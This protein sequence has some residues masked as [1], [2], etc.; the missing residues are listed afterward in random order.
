MLLRRRFE[1]TTV[2]G[3]GELCP[4]LLPAASARPGQPEN[5]V[6]CPAEQYPLFSYGTARRPKMG[7]PPE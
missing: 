5:R 7:L 6:L 4:A 1:P 2:R 3:A